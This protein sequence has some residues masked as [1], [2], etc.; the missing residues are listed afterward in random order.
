M[1]RPAHP[2]LNEHGLGGRFHLAGCLDQIHGC[3]DH[4]ELRNGNAAS[5]CVVKNS[6]IPVSRALSRD[7]AD[8]ELRDAI[9]VRFTHSNSPPLSNDDDHR[10]PR[11]NVT[12]YFEAFQ[13][14]PLRSASC[15]GTAH[16]TFATDGQLGVAAAW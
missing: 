11:G 9:E 3:D 13:I 6:N 14:I 1:T 15:A 16:S 12:H 8:E 7:V 10:M 5:H 2:F 4:S